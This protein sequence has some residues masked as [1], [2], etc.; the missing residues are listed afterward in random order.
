MNERQRHIR[1]FFLCIPE[2]AADVAA[3]Y[4][5]GIKT[6]FANAL[7]TFFIKVSHV[8]NNKLKC[9]PQNPPD[10]TILDI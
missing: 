8:F 7:I 3:V 4:P 2:S 9:L 6:L 10:G 5:K 1:N